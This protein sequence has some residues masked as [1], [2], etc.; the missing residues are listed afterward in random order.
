[1]GAFVGTSG[2]SYSHWRGVLYPE[3]LPSARW[4]EHYAG[5]FETVE[6]NATFYRLPQ[7]KTFS[8]WARRVPDGFL[9]AVKGSRIITHLRKLVGAQEALETFLARCRLLGKH[10]GPV[11]FQLPPS[12]HRDEERLAAFLGL[13]PRDLRVA[14]EFRHASWYDEAVFRLLESRGAALC[15]HDMRG[16]ASPLVATAPFAYL[17]FHG[18]GTRYGGDYTEEALGAAAAFARRC[19]R[20]GRDLFAYFNNDAQ[21][22]A[23]ENARL[24]RRMLG[25]S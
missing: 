21:G 18:S 22:Y 13:L 12:L 1:M 5:Q 24:F 4:L 7:E 8:N 2:W 23:V 15:C 11:L 16:S 3:G 17:R 25:G 10:L 20:E 6:L 9:F 19:L 14:V